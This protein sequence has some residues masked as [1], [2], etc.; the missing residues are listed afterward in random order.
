MAAHVYLEGVPTHGERRLLEAAPEVEAALRSLLA[1]M[2]ARGGGYRGMGLLRL[3]GCGLLRVELRVDVR[4][5]LGAN[6][7]DAAA[8]AARPLLERSSGGRALMCILSNAARERLAGACMELP[9][10]ELAHACPPEV[11]PEELARR[12]VLASELAREDPERAVTHNKG[13]MNGITALALATG[14]D[15]RALEAAAHAWAAKE[16]R[17]RGLSRYS[18]GEGSRGAFLRGEIELP[19]PLAAVGGSVGFHPASAFALRI[20]GYPDGTR[21]A[22]MAAC[23]GLA[24]N[25]SALVALVGEGIQK[26]HMR[27]HARRLAYRAGARGAEITLLAERLTSGAAGTGITEARAILGELRS[28]HGARP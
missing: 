17:Y 6:L 21:L 20:A 19:L 2:E 28:S 24:Q 9:L 1:S 27:L 12:I 23:L 7:L 10:T 5:A 13:I 3:Q 14:N 15:T 11:R 26:G 22:R 4:D 8:E 16:G 25:L 18:L